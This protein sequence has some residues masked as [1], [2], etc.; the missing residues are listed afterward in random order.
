MAAALPLYADISNTNS[1]T[2]ESAN[3]L[4][5][6]FNWTGNPQIALGLQVT[7]DTG[8]QFDFN[9][10]GIFLGY[11]GGGTGGAPSPYLQIVDSLN[12]VLATTPAQLMT[13]PQDGFYYIGSR[14][15]AN[16][17]EMT[18]TPTSTVTLTSGTYDL[19]IWDTGEQLNFMDSGGAVSVAGVTVAESEP[20]F[21]GD[22]APAF[23]MSNSLQPAPEPSPLALTGLGAVA[24]FL[25]RL[26]RRN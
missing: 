13:T 20:Y 4:N 1:V 3:V 2:W 6:G 22:L 7:V 21:S 17:Y 8:Y 11:S 5:T 10:L 26:Y 16:P 24:L 23:E 14:A 19:Q 9:S 18:F 25:A 15:D 12:D